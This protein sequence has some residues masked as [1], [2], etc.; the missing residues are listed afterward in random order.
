MQELPE[1]SYIKSVTADAVVAIQSLERT[2]T[3]MHLSEAEV[4]TRVN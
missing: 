4:S 2:C 3:N 1:N